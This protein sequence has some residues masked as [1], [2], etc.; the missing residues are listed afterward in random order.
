MS[1]T[2]KEAPAIAAEPSGALIGFGQPTYNRIMDFLHLEGEI[3]NHDR[4][5]DWVGLLDDDMTYTMPTRITVARHIGRGFRDANMA[6]FCDELVHIKLRVRRLM[7]SRS[8]FAEDPPSRIRRYLTNVTVRETPIATE[9]LVTS[10]V[11]LLRNRWD[12]AHFDLVAAE[13]RDIVREVGDGLKLAK[14]LVLLDMTR[15]GTPNFAIY[16]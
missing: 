6:H 5:N 2:A 11:L 13:R 16:L 8:A 12:D 9:Y 15:V 10:S 4:L 1:V 7:E 3:L 14:R